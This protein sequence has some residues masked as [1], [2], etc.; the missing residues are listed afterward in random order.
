MPC[1]TPR[2][3]HRGPN[4]AFKP[5]DCAAD[6]LV[7]WAAGGAAGGLMLRSTPALDGTSGKT[8]GDSFL[9]AT[10]PGRPRKRPQASARQEVFALY[11]GLKAT[12]PELVLG[13]ESFRIQVELTRP[14]TRPS[15]FRAH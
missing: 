12:E 7:M 2:S 15:S 1:G 9:A 4:R 5:T 13:D 8:I 6:S 3:C 11:D 10:Q 14:T